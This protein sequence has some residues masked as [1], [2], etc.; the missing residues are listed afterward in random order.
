MHEF[1]LV[2]FLVL[3]I[4]AAILFASAMFWKRFILQ[5]LISIALLIWLIA[6]N[7]QTLRLEKEIICPIVQV[8]SVQ[9]ISYT[10]TENKLILNNLTET[11]RRVYSPNSKA[12]VKLFSSGPYLGVYLQR[13]VATIEEE[14]E[15]L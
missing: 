4:C 15:K 12:V 5:F 2:V 14:I 6:A 10:D 1:F 9:C 3:S 13:K 7:L 11:T 8:G